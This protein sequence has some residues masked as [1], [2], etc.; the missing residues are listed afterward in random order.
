MNAIV[1]D[2]EIKKGILGKNEQAIPNIEYCAGW[3]DFEN[4]GISC[5]C[6]HDLAADRIQVF[7]LPA[8]AW[9]RCARPTASARSP[10]TAPRLRCGGSTA[11]SGS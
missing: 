1:Y 5:L 8:T 9:M 7:M 3:R 4:M 6:A 10:A 2:T 11:S